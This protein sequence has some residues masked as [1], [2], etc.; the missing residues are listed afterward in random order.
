MKSLAL[1][2]WYTRMLPKC[3]LLKNKQT[4]KETNE[5]DYVFTYLFQTC[6]RIKKEKQEEVDMKVLG[7]CKVK[8]TVRI[9][10]LQKKGSNHSQDTC[11]RNK[12]QGCKHNAARRDGLVASVQCQG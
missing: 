12:N 11:R 6:V 7:I 3:A 1:C 9:Q 5:E 4:N 8:A 10:S 2:V